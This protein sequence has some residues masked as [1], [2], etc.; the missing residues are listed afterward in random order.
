M[1]R[2]GSRYRIGDAARPYSIYT[3][4]EQH[5][6]QP[7]LKIYDRD[8]DQ[9]PNQHWRERKKLI[10]E[11]RELLLQMKRQ[12]CEDAEVIT[13]TLGSLGRQQQL[14][15]TPDFALIDEATQAIE[16][17]IW[18]VVPLV[19]KLVMVGDPHQLGPV[20][21]EPGNALQQDLFSRITQINCIPMLEEQHRMNAGL[22]ALIAPTY[23]PSYRPH[24]SV[25]STNLVALG[26][27]DHPL[28]SASCVW[29]DTAGYDAEEQ[30]DPVSRSVHNPVEVKL[31]VQAV[32]QLLLLGVELS[33]QLPSLHPTV[34]RSMLFVRPY[35][36]PV[37]TQ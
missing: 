14:L 22:T 20:V 30:R 17:A 19:P 31:V 27:P 18:S 21:L 32:E 25:A 1:L 10:A 11:R 16:P 2:L 37:W 28:S 26:L 5:L 36:E 3:R 34:R 6:Q 15:S 33:L 8:I 4:L 13:C 29:V 9:L 35:P 12:L 23:G 7:A 24:A